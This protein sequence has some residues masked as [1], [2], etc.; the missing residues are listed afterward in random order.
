MDDPIGFLGFD[1]AGWTMAGLACAAKASG[2]LA[3][4]GVLAFAIRR[5]AAATRH[6]VWTLGLAGAL[7]VLPMAVALPRWRLPVLT[8][9]RKVFPTGEG[10]ILESRTIETPATVAVAS[11]IEPRMGLSEGLAIPT[12]ATRPRPG[13][14]GG[15]WPLLAWLAGTLTVLAWC[16]IGFGK[17]WRIGRK[18]ERITD[19]RWVDAASEAAGRLGMTRRVTLLRGGPAAM[20]VTWGTL[21]PVILLPAEADEWTADRRR[22]V[23]MH[24]LAHVRRRDGLTQWLGLAACAA[25]WFNPLAW[26]AAS[27]LRSEREQACDDLVLEA[28]ERPSDY[29][30]QLLS[31][32]RSLRPAPVSYP[33]VMAMARPSGLE[34]RL[35]AI[36][37]PRRI[38]RGPARWLVAAGLGVVL[39]TSATLAA[40][41]LV[42][43]EGPRPAIEGAVVGADGKPIEG[44][45][46]VLLR[47]RPSIRDARMAPPVPARLLGRA[48]SDAQGKFRIEPQ[49][50]EPQVE[51]L[52][53][54]VAT[55][56]NAC[57][58]ARDLGDL[59]D[60]IVEPI[61]LTPGLPMTVRLVDLEGAPIAGAD[62]HLNSAYP[63]ASGD[64]LGFQWLTEEA[65]PTIAEMRTTDAGGR[66]KIQGVGP[67]LSL[68][69]EAR[70]AG[71]GTQT[72]RLVA[73]AG[74]NDATLTMGRAHTVEG[75]VTLGKG[76]PPAVGAKVKSRSMSSEQGIGQTLGHADVTTDADGRYRIEAAPGGSIRLE[77]RSAGDGADGY[78]IRGG[79]VVPGDSVSSRLDFVLPRGVLVTGRVTDAATG[80]PIA[81][82]AVWHQ[83]H[84]RNNP[85]FI[86]EGASNHFNG[87]E[88]K[89][90]TAADG[91]YRLGVMPGPGYLLVKGPTADFLHEEISNVD[92]QGELIWPNARNYP[93]AF[94]KIAPKP[95]DSPL[96]VAFTL[97]RG[98]T[99]KGRL[100]GADGRPVREAVLFSRLYLTKRNLTVNHGQ[101]LLPTRGGRFELGCCDPA[102]TAL[103]F[104][105]DAKGQQGAVLDISGKQ[106]G[107]DLEVKFQPCGSASVRLVGDKGKPVRAGLRPAHLEI[108]L[109]PGPSF[110][111]IFGS[112][113]SP[114]ISDTIQVGNLDRERYYQVKTDAEGRMTFPTLIPGATYRIFVH[115]Q[116][117]KTQIEFTVRPGETKDLGDLVITKL[118]RAG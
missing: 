2:V 37:D 49:A 94:K 9:S 102:S 68:H 51:D 90:I 80:R 15:A 47:F 69:L 5:R 95:E 24:E 23:L 62:I 3:C 56:P 42:A 100:V 97:R 88:Q 6:L 46:V 67:D 65:F 25:Y 40:V 59:N 70:A 29:A 53:K 8:A 106:A 111:E 75:R 109:T 72:L 103:V 116:P 22:A 48:R 43:R 96:D 113:T 61:R 55:A 10:P 108:V 63:M 30:G 115:N 7:A 66:F 18:A 73:K 105:L 12:Q 21:R 41:R 60:P 54:L 20:P 28:G 77:V 32:A 117:A 91:T 78:L 84:E 13:N 58:A 64:G 38:R 74:V 107:Q 11:T 4:A 39:G 93:D 27:S 57:F 79:L 86:K 76:G 1:V 50:E 101:D 17:V 85:Y 98:A 89:G 36:L 44:A 26:W 82:A 83:A 118:D 52:F 99:V 112:E 14:L 87:D 114:L 19:L 71:F 34:G 110:A 33:A 104:F 16:A 35:L 31:V 92:L 45:D 81:G